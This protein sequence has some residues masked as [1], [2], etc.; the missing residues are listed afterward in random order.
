M[1]IWPKLVVYRWH[2]YS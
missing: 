2:T 1:E